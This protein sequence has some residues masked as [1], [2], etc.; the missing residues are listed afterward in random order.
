MDSKI[1]AKGE[2]L[3]AK[4]VLLVLCI[5]CSVLF[6][7]CKENKWMDWKVQN[8]LW[9]EQNLQDT[10]VH[11]TASGLQYI[12]LADPTPT[13]AKPSRTSTIICDYTLRLING[14]KLEGGHASFYLPSVISGFAEGCCLVHNNGDVRI[15]IPYYLG[16]DEAKVSEDDEYNAEGNAGTEGT[17]SYIPPYSTLIYDIHICSVPGN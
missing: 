9:L 4:G 15:F 11:K 8:E 7:G 2:R 14:N 5:L 16:Y 12:I 3:M 6:F 1:K 13:D 17:N 10:A